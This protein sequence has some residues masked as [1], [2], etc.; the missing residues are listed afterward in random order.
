MVVSGEGE[1]GG[2]LGLAV[3]GL[4]LTGLRAGSLAVRG[5]TAVFR[6]LGAVLR[7]AVA[8]RLLRGLLAVGELRGLACLLYTSDAAD[9]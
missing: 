6:G 5:L 1:L 4:V 7:G 2:G 8:V 9:E 3:L